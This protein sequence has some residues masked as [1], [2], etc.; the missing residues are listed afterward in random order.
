MQI[1]VDNSFVKNPVVS[2]CLLAYNH[3]RFIQQCVDA[4][5]NQ[6]TDFEYEII[7]GEDCSTDRTREICIEYQKQYPEKIKVLLPKK[8]QGLIENYKSILRESRGEYICVCG[9]DDYW[10][11]ELK[12]QKHVNFMEQHDDVVV[13]YH[14]VQTIDEKG[15]PIDTS[16]QILKTNCTAE[17]LK[18]LRCFFLMQASCFRS[19]VTADI[20]DYLSKNSLIEDSFSEYIMGYYGRG[21]FLPEI[22]P[23]FYRVHSGGICSMQPKI[24]QELMRLSVFGEI[25]K[26]CKKKNDENFFEYY[27]HLLLAQ[28]ANIHDMPK[29]ENDRNIYGKMLSRYCRY[30]PIKDFLHYVKLYMK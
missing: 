26:T 19:V 27:R 3:E 7:I 10:C 13:T 28:F 25:M 21:E 17:E 5:V 9:C 8:N 6:K 1:L 18:S 30:I 11:D 12:L 4:A 15:T 2:V 20:Q 29:S 23:V 22:L 14:D 16:F 24:H